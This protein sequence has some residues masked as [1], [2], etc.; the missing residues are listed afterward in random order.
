[1]SI[2]PELT[3]L[4]CVS[5]HGNILDIPR[6]LLDHILSLLPVP[7]R[8]RAA[9]VCRLF[10]LSAWRA[11]RE[12]DLQEHRLSLLNSSQ[13]IPLLQNLPHLRR[14]SLKRCFKLDIKEIFLGNYFPDL[15]DLDISGTRL[16]N[17]TEEAEIIFSRV[18]SLEELNIGLFDSMSDSYIE[19][20]GT[21][22][23]KLRRLWIGGCRD[24]SV[25]GIRLISSSCSNLI[26]FNFCACYQFN[27]E[28]LRVLAESCPNTVCLDV[29]SCFGVLDNVCDALYIARLKMLK[30]LSVRYLNVTDES[31]RL[32]AQGCTKLE[33]LNTGYCER[34]S[35]LSLA[36]VADHCSEMKSV[37]LWRCCGL[38]ERGVKVLLR[39]CRMIRSLDISC[40]G[41]EISDELLKWIPSNAPNL[42]RLQLQES[43]AVTD[44]GIAALATL[45]KLRHLDIYRCDRVS[46]D[47]IFA[48]GHH[49]TQLRVLNCSGC[50]R[51]EFQSLNYLCSRC[52]MLVPQSETTV[53]V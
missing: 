10:Q 27:S 26:N 32:I 45:P 8:L 13:I 47:G 22:C 14:L 35:D 50:P 30:R 53:K 3:G 52:P 19:I 18:P 5:Y 15:I 33:Y 48:L 41:N 11:T 21:R 43:V 51:I 39:G 44:V 36:Y 2:S 16:Q 46:N 34:L 29:S 4:D 20:I 31:M 38:T 24:I 12:L 6:E 25:E 23:P 9:R 1:M 17:S 28:C 37:N 42:D 7:C 49:A 40:W